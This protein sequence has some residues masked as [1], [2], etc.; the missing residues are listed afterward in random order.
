MLSVTEKDREVLRLA[1]TL[2]GALYG[3][4]IYSMAALLALAA[5]R[6]AYEE[7]IAQIIA[8]QPGRSAD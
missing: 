2:P 6:E 8:S 7:R 3:R 5:Q 1:E 4:R